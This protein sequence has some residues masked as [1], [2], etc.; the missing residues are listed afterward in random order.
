MNIHYLEIISNDVDREIALL[1]QAQGLQFGDPVMKLGGARVAP[2]PSGGSVGVRAPMHGGEKPTVRPYFLTETLDE[3]VKALG[4]RG[5][6]IALP[7][8]TIEGRGTIAIY[9]VDG[10]EYG[11]WQL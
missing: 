8:M 9:I 2:S 6:E 5:A 11:L 10:I 3:T 1:E 7:S 4:E